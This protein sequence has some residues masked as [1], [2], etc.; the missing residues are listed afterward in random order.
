M[1][2][3]TC[4]DNP[5]LLSIEGGV[6]WIV[7]NRP[8]RYNA[9]SEAMRTGIGDALD[10]IER[11]PDVR[12]VIITGEGKAFCAGGDLTE[13]EADVAAGNAAAVA[14]KVARASAIFS[15]VERC[16]LPVIAAVNG[17]AVAGG[18]ELI[19][20]CDLVIAAQGVRIGDGHLKY[21]VLPGGGGSIRLVRKLGINRANEILLTGELL[22]AETLLDW[23]LVNR[24]VPA[25]DLRAAAGELAAV[26]ARRS[27]LGL[28]RMKHLI[29]T[30]TDLPLELALQEEVDIF[31]AYAH[32]DDFLEGLTAFAEKRDPQFTGH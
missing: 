26:L 19:L 25:D 22:A 28:E 24:I 23:G 6:A 9:L 20:C 10:A 15:R 29:R 12:A 14:A 4:A 8:E 7:L 16:R 21:G 13:F 31:G 1:S 5:I 2:V 18:L 17:V 11:A 30:A 32:S 27:P 3:T